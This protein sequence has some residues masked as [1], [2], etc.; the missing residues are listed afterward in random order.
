MHIDMQRHYL[1]ISKDTRIN[2]HHK[3]YKKKKKKKKN[4]MKVD[5]TLERWLMSWQ[6]L[7]TVSS[8]LVTLL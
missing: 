7:G 2:K 5:T 8:A 3:K 6:A 1:T 4:N